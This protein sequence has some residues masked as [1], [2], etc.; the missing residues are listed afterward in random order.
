MEGDGE[1]EKEDGGGWEIEGC[2]KMVQEVMRKKKDGKMCQISCR[3]TELHPLS[4]R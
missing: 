3:T 4:Y 1:K 2:Q